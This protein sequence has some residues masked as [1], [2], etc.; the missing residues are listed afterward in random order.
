MST[1]TT[2]HPNTTWNPGPYYL[3]ALARDIA[4]IVFVILWAIHTL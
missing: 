2:P 3:I 4:I 1:T